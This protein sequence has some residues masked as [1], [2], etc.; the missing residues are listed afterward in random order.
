MSVYKKLLGWIVLLCC[1]GLPG[2]VL[3]VPA[4]AGQSAYDRLEWSTRGGGDLQFFVVK[5]GNVFQIVRS[6]VDFKPAP[7]TVVLT[8]SSTQ[9]QDRKIYTLLNDLFSQPPAVKPK[10]Q[11]KSDRSLTGSWT[12]V[13]MGHSSGDSPPAEVVMDGRLN[14]LYDYVHAWPK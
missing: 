10:D 9:P 4:S 2:V 13:T 7:R 1:L 11:D 6:G 3:A 12:T 5:L 8:S 14:A